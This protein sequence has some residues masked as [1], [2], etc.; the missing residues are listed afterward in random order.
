VTIDPELARRLLPLV[1]DIPRW[2]ETRWMLL[3]RQGEVSGVDEAAG[4]FVV[5]EPYDGLVCV[6]GRADPA[7]IQAAAAESGGGGNILCQ[8]DDE[9]HV[10]AALPG[11]RSVPVELMLQANSL[12]MPSP[13]D[14]EWEGEGVETRFI[15]QADLAEAREVP[16]D[17]R[18][19]LQKA[20]LWTE[21]AATIAGGNPVSF[22]YPGAVTETLWDMSVDT[23]EPHRGRGYAGLVAAHV[24]RRMDRKGKRPVWAAEET[25]TASLRVAKKL[26][27]RPVDRLA[28]LHRA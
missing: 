14:E 8:L 7:A 5:R 2:I 6:A 19:A 3:D 24:I 28:V 10:A 26:G 13:D 12:D 15:A 1:P 9:A 27:F 17:L 11:W 22:C 25:N 16:D 18:E 23:L 20:L 4:T 21:L